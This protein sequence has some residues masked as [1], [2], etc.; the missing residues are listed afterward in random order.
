MIDDN[1]L[2]FEIDDESVVVKSVDFSKKLVHCMIRWFI[3]LA[4]L[5]ESTQSRT[6]F[7]KAI[8]VLRIIIPNIK[9]GITYQS[10]E[11]KEKIFA[12]KKMF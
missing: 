1:K 5:W 2:F 12:K 10:E 4:I 11:E 7:F 3:Y 8:T 6:D 9:T